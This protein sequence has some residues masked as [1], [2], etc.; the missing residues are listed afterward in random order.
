VTRKILLLPT[1]F[2]LAVIGFAAPP[3]CVA[4]DHE[5]VEQELMKMERDWCSDSV[6]SDAQPLAQFWPTTIPTSG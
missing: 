4:A 3:T 5:R 6:K 2:A 1:G